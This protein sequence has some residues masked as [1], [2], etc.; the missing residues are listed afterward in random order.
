MELKNQMRTKEMV[1]KS[2]EKQLDEWRMDTE[3]LSRMY[4]KLL[5]DK[6]RLEQDV[7]TQTE[8]LF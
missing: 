8:L 1:Q 6:K 2:K 3:S 7:S 4:G 5:E